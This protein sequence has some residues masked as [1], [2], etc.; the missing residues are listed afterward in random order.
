MPT[1][2]SSVSIEA[3]PEVVFDFVS[4]VRNLPRYFAAVSV[5][6]P[7]GDEK[8][9]LTTGGAG[10][11]RV[12]EAWFHLD[13]GRR[14]RI[15]WGS[16]GPGGYR[17]WLEVDREGQVCSVTVELHTDGDDGLDAELDRTLFALKAA[18][19]EG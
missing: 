3:T 2:K 18:I 7:T 6:E 1:Y 4:D 10:D 15:E 12:A 19:E 17:G 5:A 16:E 13:E 11:T 8:V 9:R 14:H